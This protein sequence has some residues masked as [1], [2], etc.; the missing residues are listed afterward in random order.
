MRIIFRTSS[1]EHNK[2]KL[3]ISAFDCL[4]NL[5]KNFRGINITVVA[6]SLPKKEVDQYRKIVKKND[7][8]NINVNNNS[9]SFIYCINLA[10]GF[11]K[12]KYF[13]KLTDENEIIYFVENDYIHLSNSKKILLDAFSLRIDYVSL[14]DHPDLYNNVN[15]LKEFTQSL[16]NSYRKV[17]LGKYSHW[18]TSPSTTLTFAV[19]KKTL[20]EDYIFFKKG[21]KRDIPR[22][23]KI[24]TQLTNRGRILVTP[25]PSMATHTETNY[26]APLIN[27][28]KQI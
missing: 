28:K 15:N 22:D 16:D 19:K 13:K 14:Y 27:W 21:C 17:F 12:S 5:K 10:L 7:L 9:K 26:L 3:K 2:I 4:K 6:D 20:Y 25:I 18:A 8:I 11:E 23:H 24:F 1:H